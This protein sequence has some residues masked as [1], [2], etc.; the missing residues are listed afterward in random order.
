MHSRN[1][2]LALTPALAASAAVTK[3]IVGGELATLGQFPYLVSIT[4]LYEGTSE[5]S[6]ICGGALLNPTTVLTAAHCV[7]WVLDA[8][9]DLNVRAGTLVSCA[10]N[11]IWSSNRAFGIGCADGRAVDL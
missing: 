5:Y 10:S 1:V 9:K 3:R 4:G 7:Q 6:Q 2:L 11:E 8:P